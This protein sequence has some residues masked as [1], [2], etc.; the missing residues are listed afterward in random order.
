MD[1]INGLVEY[2]KSDE[3]KEK[4]N[5][6]LDHQEDFPEENKEIIRKYFNQKIALITSSVEDIAINGD[7]DEFDDL[8]VTMW[9]E[10]RLEWNRYNCQMQYQTFTNGQADPLLMAR[11]ACLAEI[12]DTI[13]KRVNAQDLYWILKIAVNP[14]ESVSYRIKQTQKLIEKTSNYGKIS[15][16]IINNQ[17]EMLEQ[18]HKDQ[19]NKKTIQKFKSN[20]NRTM[21]TIEDTGFLEIS[22][23]AD[24]VESSV[25]K[26]MKRSNL[27]F[28][29][30]YEKPKM[31]IGVPPEIVQAI[32]GVIAQYIEKLVAESVE[33]SVEEREGKSPFINFSWSVE[34]DSDCF[35][36]NFKDDGLGKMNWQQNDSN[37][38]L[39]I[40]SEVI[41]DEGQG[42][43]LKLVFSFF[44]VHEF[45]IFELIKGNY[46]E[47]YA[48]PASKVLKLI[49]DKDIITEENYPEVFSDKEGLSIQ[50]LAWPSEFTDDQ[51]FKNMILF[52]NDK[53][54][55]YSLPCHRFIGFYQSKL[56]RSSQQS[57]LG[58]HFFGFIEKDTELVKVLDT[59]SIAKEFYEN[60]GM[61]KVLLRAS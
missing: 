34:F 2:L 56:K 7:E 23:F 52:K 16:T 40:N 18:M 30:S 49:K 41:N 1:R 29:V 58:N 20:I 42:S 60:N 27:Q 3:I 26:G 6:M 50:R 33:A 21:S 55:H 36:F 45:V 12:I 13:E 17:L 57:L 54:E 32:D 48:I 43:T 35:Y 8:V 4:L 14:I 28:Q 10:A 31:S 39:D 38:D 44:S 25:V 46:Q 51:S 53:N 22:D 11:G 61:F 59:N 47:M 15:Q 24:C 9:L 5:I 19:T 37:Q